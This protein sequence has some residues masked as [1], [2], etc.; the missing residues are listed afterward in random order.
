VSGDHRGALALGLSAGSL[1]AVRGDTIA[2][3]RTVAFYGHVGVGSV[4]HVRLAD[5]TAARL[6]IGAVYRHG[7][8]LGDLVLP[9]WL[10]RNHETARL[11]HAVLITGAHTPAAVRAL[12]AIAAR[13]P[14]AS[15]ADRG[16]F[17]AQLR[18]GD[19]QDTAA[20]WVID[21]LM[22]FVAVLAAFNTGA[23]AA[24]ERR[25]ELGL[26]R[27]AGASDGQLTR[28]VIAEALLATAAGLIAGG[29]VTAACFAGVGHDPTAGSLVVPGR[30]AALVLGGATLLG[31]CGQLIPALL[32]RRPRPAAL[33]ADTA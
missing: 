30:Q 20:P 16:R 5:G 19:R 6:R 17:L 15:V 11:D 27:L 7:S 18:A 21:A 25:G 1:S 32:A 10:A 8:G 23:I 29:L 31:V 22:L 14:G 3:S 28:T 9:A 2:V 4:L 12:R 13:T 33:A 26:A 24:A